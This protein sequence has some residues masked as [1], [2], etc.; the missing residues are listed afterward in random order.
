MSDYKDWDRGTAVE[1]PDVER[2]DMTKSQLRDIIF[3]LRSDRQ[4]DIKR[5]IYKD[6]KTSE[7]FGISYGYYEEGLTGNMTILPKTDMIKIASKEIRVFDKNVNESMEIDLVD[8]CENISPSIFEEVKTDAEKRD[9][10]MQIAPRVNFNDYNPDIGGTDFLVFDNYS[11]KWMN[12]EQLNVP[13]PSGVNDI[14]STYAPSTDYVMDF[15]YK[16]L[17]RFVDGHS[18]IKLACKRVRPQIAL[19]ATPVVSMEVFLSLEYIWTKKSEVYSK[20][21]V[22]ELI[23]QVINGQPVTITSKPN[24]GINTDSTKS[25]TKKSASVYDVTIDKGTS[26]IRLLYPAYGTNVVSAS[27]KDR[28]EKTLPK[29]EKELTDN[30]KFF[31]IMKEAQESRIK[32]G[33]IELG[34][35]SLL[36]ANLPA[37]T[38]KRYP[39][40]TVAI[41][42]LSIVKEN[43]PTLIE[44]GSTK[45]QVESL[46]KLEVELDYKCFL[47]R[48]YMNKTWSDQY[49][50]N[51]VYLGYAGMYILNPN[52]SEL[53]QLNKQKV[54]GLEYKIS[55][56]TGKTYVSSI[57]KENTSYINIQKNI[58]KP[59]KD[60][61]CES[62]Y[63]YITYTVTDFMDDYDKNPLAEGEPKIGGLQFLSSNGASQFDIRISL[64]SQLTKN[65]EQVVRAEERYEELNERL[66]KLEG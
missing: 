14:I 49:T 63:V 36:D 56:S 25:I 46:K 45:D 42:V 60:Y 29:T 6:A 23:S 7:I 26:H 64:T 37:T 3:D 18:K 59:L 20:E 2:W 34:N 15:I 38:A 28:N 61:L 33:F 10:A 1:V 35:S 62:G 24:V 40:F 47:D 48:L 16:D 5:M 65:Y 54:K 50:L 4:S 58:K 11:K 53:E 66:K 55:S 13:V 27:D 8:I 17:E 43:F 39:M 22:D 51:P 52:K 57:N 19:L 30:S 12:L 32:S 44:G 21:Q 9:L 31:D 41:D